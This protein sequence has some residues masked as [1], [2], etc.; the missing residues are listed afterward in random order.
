MVSS[1]RATRR[2]GSYG[3]V[4][5]DAASDR[6]SPAA[7]E[8]FRCPCPEPPFGTDVQVRS[9]T[10]GAAT[11]ED[12]TVKYMILTQTSQLDYDAMGTGLW[13]TG[14]N[15]PKSPHSDLWVGLA[16]CRMLNAISA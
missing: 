3:G 2:S 16:A 7:R 9:G 15:R 12:V 6:R 11:Q 13:N 8:T 1:H 14:R 5:P 10:L 4:G